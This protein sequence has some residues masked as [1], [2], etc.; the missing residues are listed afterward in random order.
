MNILIC[1]GSMA[2]TL[3][4]SNGAQRRYR[5]LFARGPYADG[6]H[7]RTRCIGV[8]QPLSGS[9]GTAGRR[10]FRHPRGS[11]LPDHQ[12]TGS[13]RNNPTWTGDRCTVSPTPMIRRVPATLWLSFREAVTSSQ[14]SCRLRQAGCADVQTICQYLGHDGCRDRRA[15]I[16]RE[17][18]FASCNDRPRWIEI[19]IRQSWH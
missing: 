10:S 15:S 18:S 13:S 17:I 8:N 12:A 16:S 4:R 11:D 6:G 2:A 3:L 9:A 14:A 7:S 19:D 1:Q 5:R